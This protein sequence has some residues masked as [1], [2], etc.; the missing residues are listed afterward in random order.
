MIIAKT[1]V[2]EVEEGIC[3]YL[4]LYAED[5]YITTLY[6]QIKCISIVDNCLCINGLNHHR[7]CNLYVDAI[8]KEVEKYVQEIEEAHKK[9]AK[10]KLVF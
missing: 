4:E 7:T 9:A 3:D 1:E 5:K 2:F 6:M 10:S 8:Q